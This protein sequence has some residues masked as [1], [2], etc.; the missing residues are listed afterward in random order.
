MTRTHRLYCAMALVPV[1]WPTRAALWN[2]TRALTAVL[3]LTLPASAQVADV[4]RIDLPGPYPDRIGMEP[5]APHDLRWDERLSG[6]DPEPAVAGAEGDFPR[7]RTAELADL[8]GILGY[9]LVGE[10]RF[11]LTGNSISFSK[12]ADCDGFSEVLIGAPTLLEYVGAAYLVSMADLEAADAADGYTDRVIDLRLVARQPRSWKLVG[13]GLHYVGISVASDGDVNGG[14]CSDLLI[15]ARGRD[16]FTGSAYV[17]SAFDLPVADA[18]DGAADGV[19]EIRRIADQPDSWELRGEASVDNAGD[20]VV[21]AGDVNGD[22][23]SD[24]LIGAPFSGDDDCGAAYLLS[25]AAL[26]SADAED[27]VAD[28]RIALAS[29]AAQ[30]ESWKL[31]GENADDRAGGGLS[32]LRLDSDGRSDFAIV[33][34]Q[35]AVGIERQGAVYLVAA[36]DL[37]AMDGADGALDGLIDL[38]NAAGGRAA[39]KLVGDTENQ[40][41]GGGISGLAAGDLDGDG[42]DEVVVSNPDW[43]GVDEKVIVVSVSDLPSA[44]EADGALDGVV[45]LDHALA[46]EDSFNLEW[47]RASLTVSSGIDI[48]GDGLEDLLVGNYDFQD[49]SACLPGGGSRSNH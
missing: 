38:G 22:S 25:G 15:G 21:F 14:G 37:P 44:D 31:V 11:S 18:A 49:G 8:E 4:G 36:S 43:D 6:V 12:D 5:N 27:G 30:P 16:Y 39:W 41:L 40:N 13:E 7:R 17:I 35:H 9:R 29:V 28:G 19:V 45:R 2:S 20:S 32:S 42:L 1:V 48:D 47:A 34:H 3:T 33:A 10:H 24:L 26:A 46:E 23:H